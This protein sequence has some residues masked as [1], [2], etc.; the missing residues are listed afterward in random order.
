MEQEKITEII[1][2]NKLPAIDTALWYLGEI[3]LSIKDAG[4]NAGEFYRVVGGKDGA[5]IKLRNMV[6][7]DGFSEE[8]LRKIERDS[9]IE[10]KEGFKFLDESSE[11]LRSCKKNLQE[12]IEKA[13]QML[14][15]SDKS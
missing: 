12:F 7:K 5:I 8:D 3:V 9:G 14:R 15:N 11:G 4:H 6:I 10:L 2:R 1:S 13:Y